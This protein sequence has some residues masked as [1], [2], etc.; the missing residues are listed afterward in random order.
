MTLLWRLIS[1]KPSA[2]RTR[3]LILSCFTATNRTVVSCSVVAIYSHHAIVRAKTYGKST[4]G[5]SR[6]QEIVTRS[7]FMERKIS[8]WS[9]NL[10]SV[11]L[12]F[13]LTT[14]KELVML[15]WTSAFTAATSRSQS[16][17]HF[18][19]GASPHCL[20]LLGNWMFVNL[21]ATLVC[22]Q[23]SNSIWQCWD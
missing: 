1:A 2:I 3:R 18:S 7:L 5:R 9:V 4:G 17:A 21:C 6:H 15:I 23:Y 12:A 8:L 10:P 11:C 13:G 20:F 16:I 22:G 14:T 19:S